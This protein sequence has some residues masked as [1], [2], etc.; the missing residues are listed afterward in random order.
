MFCGFNEKMLNG[1]TEFNEGGKGTLYIPGYLAYG[2]DPGPANKPYAA[3][4]FDVEVL[5][6]SDTKE[7]ATREK[8]V[9]DSILAAKISA[10]KKVK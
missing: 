1:L 6:V 4:Y 7:V 10:P 5:N 3:L 2:S 8:F 9:A